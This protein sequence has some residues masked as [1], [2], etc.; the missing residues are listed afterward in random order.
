[1]TKTFDCVD[2]KHHGAIKVMEETKGMSLEEELAYWDKGTR[3]LRLLQEKLRK[4]KNS[5]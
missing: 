3:E 4:Q 1:M 2:M 5:G